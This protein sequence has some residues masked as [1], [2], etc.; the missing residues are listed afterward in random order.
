MADVKYWS[1]YGLTLASDFPFEGRL[2]EADGDE[3]PDLAFKFEDEAPLRGWEKDS[4]IYESRAVLED[5]RSQVSVHRRDGCHILRFTG[6]ADY[7]LW[8]ERIVCHLLD[9]KYEFVV[10]VYLLGAAFSLWLELR[11]MP[12]LHCAA[13]VAG[14]GRA[15][16]FLATNSGG[17]TSLAA[18]LT[19]SGCRLLTDDILAVERRGVDFFGRPGYPRMRMWEDQALHFTGRFEDLEVVHPYYSKR[20][21]SV[22]EDGFGGFHS[23]P[24]PL[25]R[26]YLPE[27]RSPAE[28]GTE[29]EIIPVPGAEALV[30]LLGQAFSADIVESL[31]LRGDRFGLFASLVKQVPVRRLS[32]PEGN[33][34]LPKVCRAI[35]EDMKEA[36]DDG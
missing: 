33:E 26:F 5:G 13:V 14:D 36:N 12:A 30:S 24:A 21:V 19:R 6:V 28:R 27:R 32:Y 23:E 10:E 17:K 8:P 1:V 11:G 25:G 18:E 7:Y 3:A 22:G 20:Y 31:G 35:L 29:V 2:P 16:A 4:P 15:A 9:H 34:Y